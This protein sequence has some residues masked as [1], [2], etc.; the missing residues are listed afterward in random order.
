MLFS[1]KYTLQQFVPRPMHLKRPLGT[2][3][4]KKYVVT[5]MKHPPSEMIWGT[6]S[7]RGAAGLCFIPP[8]TTM[9]GPKY[10]VLI[11]EKLK[12]LMHVHGCTVLM[13][14]GAPYH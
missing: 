12:L 10:V 6:K 13:Q 2:R 8:N 5:T 11:K 9:T 3:F 4:D 1:D 14:D 7:L